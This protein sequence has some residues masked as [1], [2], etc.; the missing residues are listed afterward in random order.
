MTANSRKK[1]KVKCKQSEKD[2][3]YKIG[4]ATQTLERNIGF[5]TSCD[6]KTS[7]VLAIVGVLLT[8]ILTNEGL[9]EIYNIIKSCVTT[10]GFCNVVYLVCFI[11]SIFIMAMGVFKL[12]GVLI[13]RTTQKSIGREETASL[14]FFAGIKKSG[15]CNNYKEKFNVMSRED[16]LNDLIKEI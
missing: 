2:L 6:T 9:N 4:I 14:I 10:K 1:I 8:I 7:I 5:V 12:V 11:A 15:D 3:E 16:L 13:A